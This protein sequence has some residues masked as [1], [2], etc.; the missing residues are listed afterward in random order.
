[1]AKKPNP[2]ATSTLQLTAL[3][4]DFRPL[5]IS[6]VAFRVML[7]MVHQ[8]ILT[9]GVERGIT[10][11]GDYL[12]YFQIA[13]LSDE[14]GMP[15]QNWWSEF[16]PVWSYLSVV[17][18]QLQGGANASYTGFALVV[19]LLMIACEAGNLI[20]MRKIGE[21]LH[22]AN[23]GMALAW[24]YAIMLA[25][26]VFTFWNFEPLVAFF[27]L[28]S[29]WWLLVKQN[30]RS[31]VAA[32]IGALTK[33]TPALI[34]GAVWRF[35]QRN[36]ALRYTAIL[37]AVFGV[38]YLLLFIQNSSMTLPSLTS[39]FNKASYQTVWAL[40]D[41]N[42]RTGNFGPVE[43][44]TEPDNANSVQGNP[45]RIPGWLR[46]GIAAA[47]GIFV[48]MRTRRF[49]DR[50]LVAFVGITLLIFFLQAQ[51]WSPQW[52]VQ[53]IPLILLCFPTRKGVLIIVMLSLVTF[54]EYPFLFIRTGDTGGEI[55]G[56]LVM[57]FVIL[58]LARTALLVGVCIALYQKL[59]QEPIPDKTTVS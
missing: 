39:Q 34:I 14:V 59:R 6:F 38:V 35:R 22:G 18:Y 26:M 30:A 50:G 44:R 33:F 43:D 57:P 51:G 1:L 11:G 58:V 42:Y 3:L 53:V 25:P 55:T 24:I 8:P 45:A 46:L 56:A 28:L 16:P 5:L 23:T 4:S 15:F 54:A 7:L 12:T 17:I 32:G 2:P 21:Q 19:A 47:V 13:S 9:Q 31:A 20:V 10:A 52:L 49:D 41:G 27:L 37:A 29:L 48:F 36:Q 40:I